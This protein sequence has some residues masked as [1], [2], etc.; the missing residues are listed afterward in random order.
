MLRMSI[1]VFGSVWSDH[2]HR[3]SN[4]PSFHPLSPYISNSCK[5]PEYDDQ[6]R[7]LSIWRPRK[8]SMYLLLLPWLFLSIFSLLLS[9]FL[10]FVFFF[11]PAS[12]E[13]FKFMWI[14][15]DLFWLCKKAKN[16]NDIDYVMHRYEPLFRCVFSFFSFRILTAHEDKNSTKVIQRSNSANTSTGHVK[17]TYIIMIIITWN[18]WLE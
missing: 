15:D 7:T 17:L 2:V 14:T 4:T 18:K 9:L 8:F 12:L 13:C 10:L 11:L 3:I 16:L 5:Q 1:N 6:Y